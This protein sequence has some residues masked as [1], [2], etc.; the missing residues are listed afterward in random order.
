MS[1]VSYLITLPC[2]V[3]IIPKIRLSRPKSALTYCIQP[4]W[5][6]RSFTWVK[7]V[8]SIINSSW[9]IR[10]HPDNTVWGLHKLY[11]YPFSLRAISDK[12]YLTSSNSL[13]I[14]S[15]PELDIPGVIF[16]AFTSKPV[17]T[18]ACHN[19]MIDACIVQDKYLV[20]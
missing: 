9:C 12:N 17:V 5:S 7:A 14:N 13:P 3:L 6:E 2:D 8:A 10:A 16:E 1:P 15:L 11:P 20:R 4:E 19:Y 18:T